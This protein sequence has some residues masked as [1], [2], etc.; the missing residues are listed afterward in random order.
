MPTVS[1]TRWT[2]RDVADHGSGRA[3]PKPWA[4]SAIRRAAFV[5]RRGS[6]VGVTGPSWPQP[7]TDPV[8]VPG[9]DARRCAPHVPTG[10]EVRR[11]QRSG[12][13]LDQVAPHGIE[14]R[15]DPR[16]QLELLED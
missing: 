14:R 16:V 6:V 5:L 1:M 12:L 2:W 4:A 11:R 13:G 9:R 10:H 8:F 7:P 15:L 3:T